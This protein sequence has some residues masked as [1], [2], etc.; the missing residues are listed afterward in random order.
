MMRT[1]T[2]SMTCGHFISMLGAGLALAG[3]TMIPKYERPTAPVAAQYP[4]GTNV[5]SQAETNA[6]DLAWRDVFVDDRLQELIQLAITNNR[7]LRVAVL[8]V[9]QS[10]AQYRMTR[11][12]SFPTVQGSGGFTRSHAA[13]MTSEQW[14]A[15]LGTTAYEL[16]FVRPGAQPEPAGAGEIFRH[17]RSATQ[18][19][20][21][22]CV[23]SGNRILHAAPGR[24]TTC[25]G[26][27]DLEI[28]PGILRSQQG[29][30]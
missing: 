19:A 25:I 29:H 23:G 13:D 11:S 4:G 27:A 6:A 15:S 20:D 21:H 3:C 16:D 18:R 8:N 28:R 9:E 12:A 24:G 26:A 14:S 10:R 17:R 7:D 30:L 5:Q 22:T 2:A 1:K